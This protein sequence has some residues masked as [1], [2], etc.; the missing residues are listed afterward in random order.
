MQVRVGIR[1]RMC[2][3]EGRARRRGPYRV[4]G[5][6]YQPREAS[7]AYDRVVTA[8]SASVTTYLTCFFSHLVVTDLGRSS[9]APRAR[10]TIS[11]DSMPMA[12][13][14]ENSTV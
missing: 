11:W 3:K 6:A 10:L 5:L 9:G 1:Y 4:L 8:R 7:A 13:L 2:K 12:R 14:M